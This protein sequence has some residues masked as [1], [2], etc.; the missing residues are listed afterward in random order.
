M[1]HP[2]NF[3]STVT[4][5]VSPY[6]YSWDLNG[7]GAILYTIASPTYT[8][9]TAGTYTATCT[10]TDS[11]GNTESD[12]IDVTVILPTVNINV[13][14]TPSGAIFTPIGPV[15][16]HGTTP[17]SIT[18]MLAGTY[19]ITWEPLVGY[20]TPLPETKAVEQG[21]TISFHDVYIPLPEEW[22]QIF[23][24]LAQGTTPY[25]HLDTGTFRFTAPGY[26]TGVVQAQLIIAYPNGLITLRHLGGDFCI[27][28]IGNIE[29][30][31]G[32]GS[33][34]DLNTRTWYYLSCR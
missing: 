14:S 16:Y 29:T 22:T 21:E 10:V 18:G 26:D 34:L 32:G 17:W 3:S 1:G 6:T 2:V 13:T 9:T 24:D 23:H 25:I 11:L 8:Y 20:V 7:D 4:G 19:T 30:G 12:S 5:G 27:F 33:L 31:K 28:F 15:S